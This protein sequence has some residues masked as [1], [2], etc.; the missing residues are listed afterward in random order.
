MPANCSFDPSTLRQFAEK[1]WWRYKKLLILGDPQGAGILLQQS[2]E[3]F[4][5]AFLLSK[6]WDFRPYTI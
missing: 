5:K 3:K 6:R 4:L 1:D 2:V